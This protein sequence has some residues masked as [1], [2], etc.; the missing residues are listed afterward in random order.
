MEG[1]NWADLGQLSA[2]LATVYMF[3]THIDKKDA[4]SIKIHQDCEQRIAVVAGESKKLAE[5]CL[6]AFLENTKAM[7]EFNNALKQLEA[8]IK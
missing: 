4:T 3:L 6:V 1:F 7:S 2:F 8:K 5:K